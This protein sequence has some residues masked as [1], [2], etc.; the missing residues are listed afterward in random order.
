MAKY[1]QNNFDSDEFDDFEENEKQYERK[2]KKKSKKM[3]FDTYRKGVYCQNCYNESH[4]TKE[5][6]LLMKFCQTCKSNDNKIL[7]KCCSSK[8]ISGSCL[9]REIV[10]THVVQ[11]EVPVIQEQKQIQNYNVPNDQN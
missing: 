4:Y 9:S 6:K 8:A 3:N 10:P 7:I 2:I 1:H 5:C 11:I